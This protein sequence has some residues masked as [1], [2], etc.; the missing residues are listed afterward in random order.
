[1]EIIWKPV[2]GYETIYEVSNTGLVRSLHRKDGLI[3]KPITSIHGYLRVPLSKNGHERRLF[4][5]RLVAEAFIPN[6]EGKPQV[7]HINE[8]KSDNSVENL[9]WC[10][11]VE[12]INYGQGGIVRKEK[13]RQICRELGRRTYAQANEKHRMKIVQKSKSGEVINTFNSQVEASEKLHIQRSCISQCIHGKRKTA[14]GFIFER[15]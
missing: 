3:L 14:G 1:M 8:I 7:N 10:T 6:P 13:V 12:N 4:V 9:E 11:A 2:R 5:H 15:G